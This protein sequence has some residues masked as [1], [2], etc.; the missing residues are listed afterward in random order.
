M[1]VKATR[2]GL[3]GQRTKSGWLIDVTTPYVAL[4]SDAALHLWVIVTNPANFKSIKA[5]VLDV[6]PWNE[7]DTPYVFQGAR[8]HAESGVDQFGRK[9]NGAGIDLGE[10]VWRTLELTD[11]SEVEWE[12]L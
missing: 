11:N 5:V 6:G 4:P 2:E 12:F 10:L 1:L 8:P 9:T 3:V 7:H